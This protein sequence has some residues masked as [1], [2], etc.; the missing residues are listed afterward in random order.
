MKKYNLSN[1]M[2][3]AWELVKKA[4]MTISDGL[5][6]AWKEAKGME[7]TL[8]EKVIAG[9]NNLISES[10]DVFNYQISEKLWENYGKSR[11][12]FKIIETRESSRHYVE[13]DFGYIDNQK[14]VYIPG[15][16]DVFGKY[17]LSGSAR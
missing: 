10:A 6:K 5:K 11:T 14:D 9:L 2:K 7:E 13:Y 3:R 16:K 4:G 8:R 1:I 17:T 15:K 12:Y